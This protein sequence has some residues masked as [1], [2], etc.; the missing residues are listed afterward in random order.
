MSLAIYTE[1]NP[2]SRIS[3]TDDLYR[4]I[5]SVSLDG[6]VG[7]AIVRRLYVRNDSNNHYYTDISIIPI[8]VGFINHISNGK[9]NWKLFISDLVPE[10]GNWA[11]VS[12]GNTLSFPDDL[13]TT[14]YGDLA[15][16]LP[17]WLRVETPPK[18]LVQNIK[19]ITIQI[20]SIE[21]AVGY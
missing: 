13:G 21:H 7:G 19:T 18:Q 9:W 17:F 5:L 1:P 3:N 4:N 16:Y 14:G 10:E 12:S 8:D 11:L 15:T 20:I 2:E 6:Q